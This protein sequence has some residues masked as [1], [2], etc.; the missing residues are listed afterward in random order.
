MC[1]ALV[2]SVPN[3]FYTLFCIVPVKLQFCFVFVFV[4]VF[5]CCCFVYCCGCF[6]RFFAV[7]GGRG[8][9]VMVEPF[10]VLIFTPSR[11]SKVRF[12]RQWS[13]YS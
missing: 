8:L 4:F 6:E 9:R 11:K 5:C 2:K 12:H 10:C 1:A 13:P 7:F 3:I